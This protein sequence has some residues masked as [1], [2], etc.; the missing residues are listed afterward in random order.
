[1]SGS[2]GK[3]TADERGKPL[4]YCPLIL[5]DEE[6]TIGICVLIAD[7]R[8]GVKFLLLPPQTGKLPETI[9]RRLF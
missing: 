7:D 5:S 2:P 4:K 1:M 8:R 3:I 6:H 9:F